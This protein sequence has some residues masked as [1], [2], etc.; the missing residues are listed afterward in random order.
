MAKNE[1]ETQILKLRI[2]KISLFVMKIFV[3]IFE[4]SHFSIAVNSSF[5]SSNKYLLLGIGLLLGNL[6]S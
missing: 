1:D 2:K 6:V 3:V 5:E 4:I